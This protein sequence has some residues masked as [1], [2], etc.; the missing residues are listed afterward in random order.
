MTSIR[1]EL[2]F[3]LLTGLSVAVAAAAVGTYFR[4]RVE[5]NELFDHQLQEMAA[6]LT[7]APL[8]TAFR[9][10]PVPPATA[11]ERVLAMA[12]LP[13]VVAVP[14]IVVPAAA[15][16]SSAPPMPS[17]PVAASDAPNVRPASAPTAA[18]M[19]AP[20]AQAFHLLAVPSRP[21][22]PTVYVLPSVVK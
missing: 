13:V 2:L 5:A 20:F 3:W 22:G 12:M 6:S 16:V 4:A 17:P 7:D 11:P 1:R 9:N 19:A 18:P 8:E 14:K 10:V 21:S 15:P